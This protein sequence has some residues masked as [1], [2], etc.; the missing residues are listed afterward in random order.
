M[1]VR[2]D[3]YLQYN[4]R[5]WLQSVST[6]DCSARSYYYNESYGGSTGRYKGNLSAMSWKASGDGV[7]R[8]YAFSYDGLS[9]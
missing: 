7:L 4:V 1:A 2:F 5:S 3:D 6:G 9:A 8:G